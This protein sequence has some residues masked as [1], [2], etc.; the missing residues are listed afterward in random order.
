MSTR[1]HK[2]SITYVGLDNVNPET[3]E[4]NVEAQLIDAHDYASELAQTITRMK[5]VVTAIHV[6][7]VR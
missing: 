3:I 2:I 5:K 6:W 1:I 7:L 4:M